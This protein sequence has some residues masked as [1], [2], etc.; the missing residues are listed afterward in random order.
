M[1]ERNVSL[2]LLKTSILRGFLS[3]IFRRPKTGIMVSVKLR[4][5][6]ELVRK[7]RIVSDTL[8]KIILLKTVSPSAI[9][10]SSVVACLFQLTSLAT[11][12]PVVI[13]IP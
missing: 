13:R 3:T 9:G 1:I 12:G 2:F 10:F 6:T 4:P 5:G 8:F 11:S 7:T